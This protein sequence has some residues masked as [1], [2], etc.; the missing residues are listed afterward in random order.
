MTHGKLI[1]GSALLTLA[2]GC[3]TPAEKQGEA[4]VEASKDIKEASLEAKKDIDAAAKD[5]DD[6]EKKFGD[7]V[8]DANKEVVEEIVDANKEIAA[9]DK[10]AAKQLAG[11]RYERFEIIKDESEAAFATR[12]N[13]AIAR[14]QTD[15]DAANLRAKKAV[16]EDL[17]KDLEV[18]ATAVAEAKKDLTELRAK[19]G[20]VFDDGRLGVGTAIN[21]AQDNISDAYEKMAGLK[22]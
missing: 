11:D 8:A 18:A 12:A 16:N 1:I 20:K 6:A 2:L 4:R 3:E 19:T 9:A 13:A 22:M 5:L 7:K 14:V 15:L 10:D 17:N 21:K